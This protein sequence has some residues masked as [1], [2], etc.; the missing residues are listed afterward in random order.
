MVA[1][2]RRNRWRIVIIAASAAVLIAAIVVA[3]NLSAGESQSA[4]DDKKKDAPVPVEVV[5]AELGEVSSYITATANLVAEHQVTVLAE[6]EGRVASVRVEEGDAISSGQV[7]A[8]LVRDEA[9][10]AARKA[11]LRAANAE[12]A[13][14]RAQETHDEGLISREEYDRLTLEHEVAEQEVAEA[15]WRLSRTTIAAPFRGRVTER[16]VEP[17]QHVRPGDQLFTVADFDPLVARIYL[18]E[19]DVLELEVGRQVQITLG[20]DDA[21]DF[22][23]SIR[24]ISPVVD[25]AT[26]TVKV[27]VEADEPPAQV[28]PGA[29]VTVS[30]VR[31]HRSGT[32][33]LP[34]ESVIRELA[35]AHVFVAEGDVAAKRAVDL[36]LEEGDRVEVVS[37]IEP[38]DQ[39]VV[40]GQGGLKPGTK[41][42]ILSS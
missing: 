29:F 10:I 4:E 32:L 16:M 25:V 1:A 2:L 9:D 12:R 35:S 23:G 26:G 6:A 36:G 8:A 31:E 37:G 11:R 20:A 3:S 19:R 13:V 7:L 5:E 41:L 42:K 15:E 24:Q 30:I 21:Y 14:T 28:R 34:R 17:G 40:A 27:T 22:S 38:G 33:L 18:P 39:V